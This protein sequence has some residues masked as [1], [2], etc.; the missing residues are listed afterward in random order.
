[1]AGLSDAQRRQVGQRLAAL[2][3]WEQM[4]V[5]FTAADRTKSAA[6]AAFLASRPGLCQSTLYAWS[7]IRR[8]Q[9][10]R[11]LLDR[12]SEPRRTGD[13]PRRDSEGVAPGDVQRRQAGERLAILDAWEQM[14]TTFAA[15][16]RGKTAATQAFLDAHPGLCQ[17]TLYAW[18]RI[19]REE[20]PRGLIDRRSEPRRSG[21]DQS[22]DGEGADPAWDHFLSIYLTIHR[23][24]VAL[25]HQIAAH[26]A[27]QHGWPWPSLR[28]IQRRVRTDLP[29]VHA[30]YWRLGE[31]EWWR[32]YRPKLRR[33]YSQYRAGEW[34]VGDFHP[35]DV[36]CRVSDT[37][38]RIVRPLL[39]AFTDLRSR[40]VAGWHL[41]LHENQDAVLLAFRH[42]VER[43]GPPRHVVIDNGKPYRA[44]GVSGG[45][46]GP[47]RRL[48]EDEDYVHGVMGDLHVAVHFSIPFNPDSKPIERWFGTFESQFCATF[49]TYCGGDKDDRFRAAWKLAQD[50]PGACPTVAELATRLERYLGAYHATPHTGDGMDGMTPLQ[51]FAACDP[52]PRAVLPDGALDVLLMRVTKPVK[53]SA[54]GVRHNGIEYG[55]NDPRLF[56]R[57]GQEVTLR[58]HPEDPS[59]VIVCDADRRPLHKAFNNQLQ[60]TGCSQD[61]VGAGIRAQRRARKLVRQVYEGQTKAARQSVTEAAISARLHAAQQAAAQQLAATGTDDVAPPRNVTPLRTAFAEAIRTYQRSGCG[62]A[63][64]GGGDDVA[65]DFADLVAPVAAGAHAGPD[66]DELIDLE[67]LT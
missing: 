62:T 39:S 60:R 31:R 44:Y 14:I 21:P 36:F 67:D 46:P 54:Y 65:V 13:D 17:S 35:V 40:T 3:A 45:R 52:I 53:I 50:D 30:D 63:A 6:T 43:H 29:A 49:A 9:G 55:Q 5:A 34:L 19:R 37:D 10:A 7:R 1:M 4:I 8:E 58:V 2:D 61:D 42:A 57:Q 20:G 66:E 11:G 48:I 47:K 12:R 38:P 18:S 27:D 33:D 41:G 51:A 15:V 22:R 24:S 23:R 59:Y 26:A 28:A 16:G 25:C 32:R 64:P 56:D